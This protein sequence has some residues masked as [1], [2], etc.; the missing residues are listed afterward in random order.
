MCC[1]SRCVSPRLITCHRQLVGLARPPLRFILQPLSQN[2]ISAH[3]FS[4]KHSV[5]PFFGVFLWSR[6]T[7]MMPKPT[8]H[9][10]TPTGCT[11]SGC[12]VVCDE[13]NHSTPRGSL[14]QPL[15]SSVAEFQGR[16]AT[17]HTIFVHSHVVDKVSGWKISILSTAVCSLH[18]VTLQTPSLLPQQL[19]RRARR[20]RC[21]YQ[22]TDQ[23]PPPASCGS[24][25]RLC[26]GLC[27]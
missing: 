14:A 4:T 9:S 7:V 16:G 1:T 23:L 3:L 20:R 10:R 17:L 21:A 13:G 8:R 26:G 6:F 22:K 19:R 15:P 18:P 27:A 11:G 5:P 25:S 2:R 12:S 24:D